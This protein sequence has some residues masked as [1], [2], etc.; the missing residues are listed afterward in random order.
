MLIPG[1]VTDVHMFG[2]LPMPSGSTSPVPAPPVMPWY[3][4]F[5]CAFGLAELSIVSP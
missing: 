3:S 2:P 1:L 5:G 4:C